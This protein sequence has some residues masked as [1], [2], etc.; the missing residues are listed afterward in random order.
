M[1]RYSWGVDGYG[2]AHICERHGSVILFC[3]LPSYHGSLGVLM[4]DEQSTHKGNE[5]RYLIL[6]DSKSV[7]A[8][9]V[10]NEGVCQM[11]GNLFSKG[12]SGATITAVNSN[13]GKL[14]HI[15]VQTNPFGEEILFYRSVRDYVQDAVFDEAT[16]HAIE[17]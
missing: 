15:A 9:I 10:V 14:Q 13:N 4:I 12:G 2:R 3:M 7:G 6:G 11:G 5:M 8:Q 16:T 1:S 17:D